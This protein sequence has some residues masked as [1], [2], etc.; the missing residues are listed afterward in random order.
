VER[1]ENQGHRVENAEWNAERIKAIGS[2][3]RSGT[4]RGSRP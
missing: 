1:G 2:R 4:R 3:T